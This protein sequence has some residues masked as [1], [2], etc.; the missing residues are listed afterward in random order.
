[1]YNEMTQVDI[2]M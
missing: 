1:M 2:H